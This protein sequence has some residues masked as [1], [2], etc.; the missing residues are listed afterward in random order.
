MGR[1]EKRMAKK[2]S[3]KGPQYQGGRPLRAPSGAKS[4]DVVPRSVV[5]G[6]LKEVPVFG[7]MSA[8]GGLVQQDGEVTYYLSPRE[9]EKARAAVAGGARLVAKTLDE[10]KTIPQE[11]ALVQRCSTPLFCIDGMQTTATESGATSLP[12][13]F[14]KARSPSPQLRPSTQGR[15]RGPR[16]CSGS[17]AISAAIGLLFCT[18]VDFDR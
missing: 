9:A 5:L 10:A 15:R 11:R 7:L 16:D 4:N 2:R 3:R 18:H 12:I 17:I 1:A 8:A 14:S 6:R 13:F